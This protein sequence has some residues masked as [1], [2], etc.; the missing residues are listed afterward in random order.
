MQRKDREKVRKKE[1]KK[2]S[3]HLE[4]DFNVLKIFGTA[5]ILLG[6]FCYFALSYTMTATTQVK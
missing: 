2:E 6:S 4:W 5:T 1:G 3:L